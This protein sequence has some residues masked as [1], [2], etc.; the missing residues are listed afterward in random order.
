LFQ[1]RKVGISRKRNAAA[2]NQDR[3]R[4]KKDSKHV[5]TTQHQPFSSGGGC[6]LEPGGCPSKQKRK[7]FPLLLPSFV[8]VENNV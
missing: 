8:G 2:S 4:K 1:V 5:S 6:R 7:N 3:K